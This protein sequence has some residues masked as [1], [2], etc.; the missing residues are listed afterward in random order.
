MG[1]GLVYRGNYVPKDICC[2]MAKVRSK[3]K[4]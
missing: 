3:K 2:A 1:A 4:I